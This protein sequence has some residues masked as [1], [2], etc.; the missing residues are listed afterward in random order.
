MTTTKLW[1]LDDI[2]WDRFDPALVEPNVLKVVK[3]AALVE[4]NA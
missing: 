4:F 3:A 2:P 1:T